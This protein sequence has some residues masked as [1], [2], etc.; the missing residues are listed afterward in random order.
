VPTP[1]GTGDDALRGGLWPGTWIATG[2][3]GAGKTQLAVQISAHAALAGVPVVHVALEMS[4]N[5]VMARLLGAIARPLVPWSDVLLGQVEGRRWERVE[6]AAARLRDLPMRIEATRLTRLPPSAI[7]ELCD[8]VQRAGE[9][10]RLIVL[11]GVPLASSD[12]DMRLRAY[13]LLQGAR[14]ARE[15]FDAALLVVAPSTSEALS[16]RV[17]PTAPELPPLLDVVRDL[18]DEATSAEGVMAL[19]RR[20]GGPG[21]AWLALPKLRYAPPTS[22][23]LYF[24]GT[25]F[26][27]AQAS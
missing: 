11:D 7:G 3:P 18:G 22:V 9:S 6:E 12:E 23:E 10:R 13:K 17:L 26:T 16:P 27:E 14:F 25:M 5:E 4:E 21:P 20:P 8:E 24:S 19:V 15:R 2:G 1:W